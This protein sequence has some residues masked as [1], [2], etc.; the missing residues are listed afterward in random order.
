MNSRALVL[1]PFPSFL[2]KKAY[3]NTSEYK[4]AI[5]MALNLFSLFFFFVLI[6]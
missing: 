1:A 2:L 5:E 3:Q 4:V 6:F